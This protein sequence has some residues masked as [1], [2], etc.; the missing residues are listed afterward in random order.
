MVKLSVNLNKV[1]L[2]RNAREG[3]CPDLAEH[4]RICLRAGAHGI[5]LHPRPDQRHVRAADTLALSQ[6]S[7]VEL[8]I[9]GNPFEVMRHS[10]RADV[11]DYPGF[12]PLV[13]EVRPSQC[14]LVPDASGQ[15][16]SDHGFDLRKDAEALAPIVAELKAAKIRVSLFVDAVPRQMAAAAALGADRVE[17]Y[18]GP[19]AAARERG[20]PSEDALGP[21]VECAQAARQA[22]LGLNAGHDLNL[23]NLADFAAAIPNLLEVSIGHALVADALQ[24]GMTAAVGAYLSC[25]KQPS[26]GA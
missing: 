18:T 23:E 11:G 4:A 14:T 12:L 15:L 25:L 6:I 26:T 21:Y 9:E 1:A 16:T 20:K 13:R 7:N 5:T 22:G 2:I 24:M 10:E 17:L 3:N 19:Y 8:N